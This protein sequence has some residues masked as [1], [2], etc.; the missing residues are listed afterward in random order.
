[1]TNPIRRISS[2]QIHSGNLVRLREDSV[3]LPQGT[4]ALFEHVQIKDGASTLAIE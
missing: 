1:M 3:I 2:R 4:P